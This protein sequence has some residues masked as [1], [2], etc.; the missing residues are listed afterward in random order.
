MQMGIG[1]LPEYDKMK[2][3]KQNR[4]DESNLVKQTVI[5]KNRQKKS[6]YNTPERN[7]MKEFTITPNEAGQRLDKYLRKLL[8]KAQGSFLYKMLRKKNIVL[9][10][11]KSEGS[12]HLAD[13]DTVTLYLADDTFEKFCYHKAE[14]DFLE[15]PVLKT[16]P[17]LKVLYE[18]EDILIVNKPAGLLSQKAASGDI[19]A[20]ELI[21]HYLTASGAVTRQSLQTFRPSVCNRLDRNTSGILIAGKTLA[22]LQ[23]MSRQLK[24]RSIEKYYRCIV[25]GVLDKPQRL[26]GYLKKDEKDNKAEISEKEPDG[27]YIETEYRPVRLYQDFTLLEVHLIT[28]RSHQIRAHLASIGHPVIGDAKYGDQTV[29]RQLRKAIGLKHQLLHAYRIV[30]PDGQEVTA[31]LPEL[32]SAFEQF[33]ESHNAHTRKGQAHAYMEFPRAARLDT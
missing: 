14:T 6:E 10:G 20:N 33:L 21:I 3:N 25:T 17:V 26:Q 13:G 16:K 31:P 8:P 11:R 28:G 19:S 4:P 15:Q 30:F 24:E 18:N 23:M 22:G 12:V 9:N 1:K 2:W 5:I 27:R 7:H 29:N 32:F